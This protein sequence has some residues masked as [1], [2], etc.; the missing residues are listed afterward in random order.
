MN[1][2]EL[3]RLV[4]VRKVK[5]TKAKCPM[6]KEFLT[7]CGHEDRP[8]EGFFLYCAACDFYLDLIC[9]RNT[10]KLKKILNYAINL[11]GGKDE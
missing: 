1:Q 2:E 9:N 11:I 7:L 4:G 5:A 6:C 8:V 3:E 10:Q